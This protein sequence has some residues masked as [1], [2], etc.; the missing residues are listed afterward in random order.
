MSSQ[1]HYQGKKT[2]SKEK[3]KEL[4]PITSKRSW[5]KYLTDYIKSVLTNKD[6]ESL[7]LQT[8]N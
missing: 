5:L 3:K 6:E 2:F 1:F 7:F 4:K 8:V